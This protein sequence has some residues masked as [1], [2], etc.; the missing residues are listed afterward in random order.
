MSH[1]GAPPLHVFQS[2]IGASGAPSFHEWTEAFLT[3]SDSQ[4][5]LKHM[6]QSIRAQSAGDFEAVRTEAANEIRPA[7]TG[8][9]S[10]TLAYSI[11][12]SQWSSVTVCSSFLRGLNVRR[13]LTRVRV[14]CRQHFPVSFLEAEGSTTGNVVPVVSNA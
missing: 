14:V 5:S 6:L 4:F 7:S 2:Q 12:A 10:T 3:L 11:W 9:T 1:R 13:T 8:E